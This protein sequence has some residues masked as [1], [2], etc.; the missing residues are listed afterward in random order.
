[1]QEAKKFY[2]RNC[3]TQGNKDAKRDSLY[4]RN[5]VKAEMKHLRIMADFAIRNAEATFQSIRKVR[6]A[7]L[8]PPLVEL[9]HW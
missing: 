5:K 3:S 7:E 6:D 8:Q 9:M 1:M 4:S 2:E